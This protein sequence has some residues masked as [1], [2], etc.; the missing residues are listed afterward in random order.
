MMKYIR[1]TFFALVA[2]SLALT[3]CKLEEPSVQKTENDL[4][5]QTIERYVALG[6]SLTAGVQSGSLVEDF[7]YY[8]FPAQIARQLGIKEFGQPTVAYPGIPNVLELDPFTLNLVKAEGTG[9]PNNTTY[10]KP[11]QNLG[12]PT[13]TT[14]DLLNA[15][16]STTNFRYLFFGEDNQAVDLVLRGQGTAFAQAKAQHPD[17]ITL[18]IGNND[19]LGYATSGGLKPPTPI[20]DF[21]SPVTGISLQGFQSAYM[22]LADSV[23]SLGA[24]VV[25]ANVPDV[26]VPPFFKV[27]GP[28]I[29]AALAAA[30]IP[31]PLAYEKGSDDL[32]A[33]PATGQ[34]T[35][36]NLNNF[37]VLI[38]LVG[39][40]YAGDIGKPTGHWY[41]DLAAMKG[42]P[43]SALLATMP[44][45]DT[46]QAFG[47]HPQNP[48]PSALILDAE[49]MA[50]IKQVTTAY[51]QII[52]AAANQYGFALFDA[53]GFLNEILE[54][55]GYMADGFM[56]TTEF[57]NGGLFSLDGIHL[58][59][60][61]YAIVANKFID[62]LNAKYGIA[63]AHISVRDALGHAPVKKMAQPD[64][65]QYDLHKMAPTLEM[66]GGRFW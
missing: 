1:I 54:N 43:V 17:L 46:T 40:S 44:A 51:N 50:T 34:A 3:G 64:L 33:G 36:D 66:L 21:V 39:A 13:A 16:T 32:S 37:D 48:W 47:L 58:T 27:V 19:I 26:I 15:T 53:N 60:A 22:A 35:Q 12:I 20:N 2:L 4:K 45:V 11:Y 18:W 49:E 55:H 24:K 38:T 31:Y 41:R 56:F 63:I 62:A 9:V 8:S 65:T 29:A 10:P 23:A 59:N 5:G 30:N 14:W 7:Q 57:V 28:K 42:V 25:V 6:N 52:A 61:G